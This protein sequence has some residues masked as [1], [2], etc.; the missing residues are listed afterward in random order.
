MC[1][2]GVRLE[3]VREIL[4]NRLLSVRLVLARTLGECD[5]GEVGSW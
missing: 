1:W 4:C 3:A 5:K 2:R